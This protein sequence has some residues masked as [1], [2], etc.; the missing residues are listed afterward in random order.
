M[1]N[2]LT[3]VLVDDIPSALDNLKQTIADF[4]ESIEIIGE[5]DGVVKG[6]KLIK[7]LKPDIAFLDIEMPDGTGFDIIDLLPDTLQTRIIF[8]TGS[9][10]YAI[11][12][13]RYAA[14]DYLLK[15]IDPDDLNIAVNKAMSQAITAGVA[16]QVWKDKSPDGIPTRLALHTSDE[17]MVVNITDIVRCQSMD[18]Y[19]HVHLSS[20]KKVFMSKPLKHFAGLL[21]PANF[22]RV[23]QS[24]LVNFD[25]IQS[26]VKKEGGYLLLKDESQIPVSLRKRAELMERMNGEL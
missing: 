2:K 24:H 20:G 1:K 7:E 13:F 3:A 25:C 15:P 16:Q 18:N 11:K 10:E 12:A 14:V 23:H 19:C 9:E 17:V 6:A 26:F 22:I 5:A 4:V 21:E 8:T